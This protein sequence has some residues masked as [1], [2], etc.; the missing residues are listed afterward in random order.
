MIRLPAA[1]AALVLFSAPAVAELTDARLGEA[2]QTRELWLAFDTQPSAVHP[3]EASGGRV[4]RIEGVSSPA[5]VIDIALP[6]A[7]ERIAL[8]PEDADTLHVTLTGGLIDPHAELRQG[9]VLI[10]FAPAEPVQ[11]E[12]VRTPREQAPQL[13]ASLA[14]TPPPPEEAAGPCLETQSDIAQSPWDL[15]ALTAHAGCLSEAGL[16]DQAIGLYERVLAFEPGRYEAAIGLAR[17]REARG[18]DAAARDLFLEAA[19]NARTD[20]EALQARAAAR[21]L[22]EG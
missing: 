4:F 17:L 7:L 19:R 22:D 5:R 3:V 1:S 12:P 10:R 13:Q 18:E 9:G 11:A 2:G 14:E 8:A 20:G 6:G 15:D 16:T 21:R